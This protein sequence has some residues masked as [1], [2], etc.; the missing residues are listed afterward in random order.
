MVS[1][2]IDGEEDVLE[3]PD[4]FEIAEILVML[5]V[6]S[7]VNIDGGGSSVATYQGNKLVV[8][9]VLYVSYSSISNNI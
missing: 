2:V 5:G 4:L 8:V 1:L 7:A 6:E 9:I 3:G